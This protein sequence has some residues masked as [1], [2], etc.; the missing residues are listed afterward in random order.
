MTE[1]KDDPKTISERLGRASVTFSYD[2]YVK[3]PVQTQI[4]AANGFA[5]RLRQVRSHHER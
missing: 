1:V 5:R 4:D 2:R 3:S